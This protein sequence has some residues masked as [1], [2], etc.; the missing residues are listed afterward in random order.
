MVDSRV[1]IKILEDRE[2]YRKSK[3]S[4]ADLKRLAELAKE[5][6]ELMKRLECWK[7][8]GDVI[9]YRSGCLGN[10]FQE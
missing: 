3:M 2:R 4:E 7:V 10:F 6:M 5:N 8:V 1:I 9:Y